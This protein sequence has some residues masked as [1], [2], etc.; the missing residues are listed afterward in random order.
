MLVGARHF[1]I[2]NSILLQTRIIF[3]IKVKKYICYALLLCNILI[4]Y[5]LCINQNKITIIIITF[6]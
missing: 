1:C 2:A 5:K 6:I 3:C 4:T